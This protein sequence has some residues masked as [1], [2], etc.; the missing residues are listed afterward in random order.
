V[1]ETET[2][3]TVTVKRYVLPKF[4]IAVETDRPYYLVGQTVV[5][6]LR[7]EYFF[8]KPVAQGQV[9]LRGS[10]YAIEKQEVMR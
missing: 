3:K 8:G 7:A 5:G 4:R 2:E 1:G 9:E 10:V 6:H